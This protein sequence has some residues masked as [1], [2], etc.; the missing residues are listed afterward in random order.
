MGSV[1]SATNRLFNAGI[2]LIY[3]IKRSLRVQIQSS[4]TIFQYKSIIILHSTKKYCKEHEIFVKLIVI[5][6]ITN[7]ANIYQ[8]NFFNLKRNHVSL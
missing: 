3:M 5:L 4:V 7:I 2:G 6:K 8:N 1:K